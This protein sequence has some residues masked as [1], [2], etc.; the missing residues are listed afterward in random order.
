MKLKRWWHA[1]NQSKQSFHRI[2]WH[3]K[4]AWLNDSRKLISVSDFVLWHCTFKGFQ[5]R[6]RL[7]IN[8]YTSMIICCNVF[9]YHII[10]PRINIFVLTVTTTT[11]CLWKGWFKA[12]NPQRSF[13]SFNLSLVSDLQPYSLVSP[14]D[15]W[16]NKSKN[17]LFAYHFASMSTHYTGETVCH[18]KY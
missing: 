11:T 7:S 5:H 13:V 2:K 6:Y 14:N 18:F 8:K 12:T 9:S 15:I 4:K 3:G 16:I 17:Q 1:C 10:V